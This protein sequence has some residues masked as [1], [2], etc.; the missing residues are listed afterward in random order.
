[1]RFTLVSVLLL[2][3]TACH[4]ADDATR[5]SRT[6]DGQKARFP[7]RRVADGVKAA[8]GVLESCHDESVYHA[9]ELKKAEQG[10]HVRLVFAKPIT[11]TVL[12]DRVEVSEVVFGGGVFWVRSG[13]QVRRYCKYTFEKMKPFEAWFRQTLPVD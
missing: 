10:D 7:A 3:A 5:A 6:L 8:I 12:G 4:G 9:A 1:M 13:G 11:V 2:V